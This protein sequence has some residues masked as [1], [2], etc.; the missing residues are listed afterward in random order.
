MQKTNIKRDTNF[1]TRSEAFQYVEL[2]FEQAKIAN[3]KLEILGAKT[4]AKQ[5]RRSLRYLKSAISKFRELSI[6]E[7][8]EL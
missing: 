1:K 7:E 4:Y 6:Q 5:T 8:K 3:D 2:M